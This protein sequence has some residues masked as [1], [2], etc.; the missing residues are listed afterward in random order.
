MPATGQRPCLGQLSG[1]QDNGQPC[2][3]RA[4]A[5]AGLTWLATAGCCWGLFRGCGLGLLPERRGWGGI[6]P[7]P[8]PC[9]AHGRGCHFPPVSVAL[10]PAGSQ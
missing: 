4:E 6:L 8:Q 5:T 9:A 10:G 3:R 1:R 7:P 2:H